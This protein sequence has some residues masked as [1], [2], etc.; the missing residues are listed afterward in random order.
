ME[1]SNAWQGPGR[2]RRNASLPRGGASINMPKVLVVDRDVAFRRLV[3]EQ[4]SHTFEIT[5]A[6]NLEDAVDLA[7]EV[8][9]D[10]VL[11]DLMLPSPIGL[12]LCD[13]LQSLSF[14]E[15]ISIFLTDSATPE[16]YREFS[17]GAGRKE[18]FEKPVDFGR[19]KARL[20]EELGRRRPERRRE[21][22]VRLR[23]DLKLRGTDVEGAQFEVRTT[24]DNVSAN[25]F[26]CSL[27]MALVSDRTVLVFCLTGGERFVGV[28]RV[29]RAA[30]E[31][32]KANLERGFQFVE[33]PSEWIL[34]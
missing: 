31:G 1:I 2:S 32:Q 5:E 17:S 11:L 26:H 16:R 28:A 25:G 10:F 20:R 29:I 6:D 33:K 8:R 13:R 24:T 18:Y 27:P 34:A 7:L 12:G 23:I 19:L 22:R 21:A 30:G 15:P 4:L 9:P 14:T 3:R